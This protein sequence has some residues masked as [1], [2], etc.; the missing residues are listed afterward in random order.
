MVVVPLSASLSTA[1]GL[2]PQMREQDPFFLPS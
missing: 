2:A 1:K